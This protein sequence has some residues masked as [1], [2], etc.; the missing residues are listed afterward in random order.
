MAEYIYVDYSNLF[1]GAEFES[2]KVKQIGKKI[3]RSYKFDFFKLRDFLIGPNRHSVNRLTMITST[4]GNADAYWEIARKA[5]FELI[6]FQRESGEPEKMVDT[7]LVT[8]MMAD[9]YTVMDRAK[10]TITL[11]SGDSDFLPPVK[12]LQQAGFIIEVVFWDSADW[13]LREAASKF[14]SMSPRIEFL[15]LKDP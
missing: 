10:D 1:I 15:A 13:K 12:K 4:V 11:V 7:A 5:G 9:A 14:I 2:A 8:E 3:D 6:Q